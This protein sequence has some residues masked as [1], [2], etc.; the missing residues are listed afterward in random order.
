M[1][2]GDSKTLTILISDQAGDPVDVSDADSITYSIFSSSATAKAT[3]TL[4]DGI[5]VVTSTVTVA[6]APADTAALSAGEYTHELQVVTA[7]L[8]VYTAMQGKLTVRRSY[9]E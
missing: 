8:E 1:Y 9:I 7:A 4:A 3:K 2:A 5:T 6:L